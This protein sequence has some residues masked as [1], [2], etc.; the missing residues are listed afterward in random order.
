[1]SALCYGDICA[2]RFTHNPCRGYHQEHHDAGVDDE[3][4]GPLAE[5]RLHDGRTASCSS[6]AAQQQV[7][8]AFCSP[9]EYSTLKTAGRTGGSSLSR[10]HNMMCVMYMMCMMHHCE[11]RFYIPFAWHVHVFYII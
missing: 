9:Q 10:A 5:G 2:Q 6:S 7:R 8:E 1:M 4:L 3:G 11:V